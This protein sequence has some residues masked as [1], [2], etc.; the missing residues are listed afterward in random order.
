MVDAAVGQAR[1][2]LPVELVSRRYGHGS[3]RQFGGVVR[4]GGGTNGGPAEAASVYGTSVASNR[5]LKEKRAERTERE[6][7]CSFA[8]E[9]SVCSGLLGAGGVRAHTHTH[10]HTHTQI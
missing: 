2:A 8:D 4:K 10:A 1:Q 5:S 9:A 6:G 3:V 7:K